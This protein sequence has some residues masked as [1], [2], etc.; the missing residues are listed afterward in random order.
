MTRFDCGVKLVVVGEKPRCDVGMPHFGWVVWFLGTG[1]CKQFYK[2][3]HGS[4]QNAQFICS[5]KEGGLCD[6]QECERVG[7]LDFGDSVVPQLLAIL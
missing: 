7:L 5:R 3:F 6:G 2:S 1:W 4:K